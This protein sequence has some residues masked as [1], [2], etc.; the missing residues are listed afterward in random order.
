M[1]VLGA[2][3]VA[4]QP[5]QVAHHRPA[6]VAVG[7]REGVGVAPPQAGDQA[8]VGA[9]PAVGTPRDAA[10]GVGAGRGADGVRERHLEAG[11][12]RGTPDG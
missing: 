12:E 6:V 8:V 3:G 2:R 5:P 11:Y 1:D 10:P 9:A 4:Q 7:L